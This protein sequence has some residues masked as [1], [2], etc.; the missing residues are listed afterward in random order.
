M[1]L[2]KS[3]TDAEWAEI[4]AVGPGVRVYNGKRTLFYNGELLW[5]ED[6][7]EL[8]IHDWEERDTWE[9]I[10]VLPGVEIIP[11]G[12]FFG[13]RNVKKVIM[14][15]SVRRIEE[16]AFM[17][18]DDLVFVKLSRNLEYI[19]R[20][21][22]L[23]CK[24]LTSIFIP[25]TCREIGDQV[26]SDCKE[27]IIPHTQLGR[28]VIARTALFEASPFETNERGFYSD[29]TSAQVNTWVKSINISEGLSLH[30]ICSSSNPD[31]EQVYGYVKE[32]AF[33]AMKH[34]NRIGITPSQYL[35]ANPYSEIE[36]GKIVKRY[37]LEMMGEFVQEQA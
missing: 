14:T 12:T 23:G 26:L 8:L 29:T 13:C 32:Y 18:C 24:S 36:E 22:F 28:N 34:P 30:R 27:L 25:L 35:V 21:S 33:R 1:K 31:M 17:E 4:V 10:I 16:S 20:Y 3:L 5:E 19:G 9:A 7:L 6:T 15:D 37:I 11:Q 2:Q